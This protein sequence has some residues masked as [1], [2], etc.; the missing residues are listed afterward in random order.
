MPTRRQ[1]IQKVT[2]LSSTTVTFSNIPQNYTD[3]EVICSSRTDRGNTGDSI[4]AQFNGDT[5]AGNY[6]NRI[7]FGTGTGATSITANGAMV[8]SQGACGNSDTANT[9]G[10]SRALIP[11]YAQSGRQ[12]ASTHHG[13]SERN[14]ATSYMSIDAGLWSSTN[15][16]TSMLLRPGNGT[17]FLAGS[18]FYL[19]GITH[20]PIIN[21]GV[22]S[23]RDGFKY[24]TFRSTST[25][26]VVEPGDVEYLVVAGGGGG[27]GAYHAAGG[28]GGA[29]GIKRGNV[30]ISTGLTTFTIGAGGSGGVSANGSGGQGVNGSGS[31][32]G[33]LVTTTG[34]GGGG[35]GNLNTGSGG[36]SNGLSGGS[37][38]G[39]GGR[40][41]TSGGT[42]TSG[43]GNNGGNRSG[44]NSGGGG[45]A[46][47]AGG[48][49]GA[50]TEGAAGAGITIFDGVYATG[51]AGKVVG[52]GIAPPGNSNT[53]NGGGPGSGTGN[54]GSAG[55]SGIVV[56]RYPYDGN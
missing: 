19:Y 42:G 47:G 8:W 51:S 49:A 41:G 11:N 20:V 16:I 22:V 50:S 40:A 12:K 13:N 18:T 30:R 38:G 5:T 39:A 10:S 56:I 35:S 4:W 9:F 1:L 25:L 17:N 54:N 21:G 52:T 45:G 43:E 31:S 26:Q 15:P 33:S 46:G 3:L 7:L 27:G 24:H 53:G 48:N 6:S 29:G 44:D 37:G 23:I 34:G 36:V 14:D 2:L 32:L 28:G 55:G